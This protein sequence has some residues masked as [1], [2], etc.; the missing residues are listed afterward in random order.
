VALVAGWGA[1]LAAVPQT[2]GG[3]PPPAPQTLKPQTLK[4]QTLK[5]QTLKPLKAL[6]VAGGCC[7]D[8][9][10]QKDVLKAGIEARA[11]V[12]VDVCY[13]PDRSTKARFTC[14]EKEDWSAGYDVVI[15]DECSSDVKEGPYVERILN[16]HRKGLPAVNL[17]CAM[18]SYRVGNDDWFQFLGL[19]S[20]AHGPQKPI[21]VKYVD[22]EH[23]I[24]R[25][26]NDWTTVN[27]ELY[28]NLRIFDTAKPL[29]RGLQDT[30]K[31]VDDYV[32]TWVNQYGKTRVFCTT[33]G[34]NTATVADPRYLELVTRG[35]LWSCDKL[36]DRYLKPAPA[37]TG[38]GTGNGP[39]QGV[40][41]QPTP[42]KRS[43]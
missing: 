8:Y 1:A 24:T 2:L 12:V 9:E 17:H 36:D 30:G 42:A 20:M 6:L 13:S 40:G 19:H 26:L 16:A 28:N 41:P 21:D 34:H 4:P 35:L 27:E 32:V 5:P 31:K 22:R 39:E 29:A 23:P 37:G 10:K 11:H 43:P 33:L 7:H 38:A 14:Y 15:H 3:E 25:T 18:H